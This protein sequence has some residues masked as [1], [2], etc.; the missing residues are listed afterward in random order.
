[1]PAAPDL[2]A[3]LFNFPAYGDSFRKFA[4]TQIIDPSSRDPKFHS[5]SGIYKCAYKR[6]LMI[7]CVDGVYVELVLS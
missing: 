7:V 3:L 2:K 4:E 6:K 1:M 5:W